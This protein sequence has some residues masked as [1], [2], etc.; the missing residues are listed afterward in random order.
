M[1]VGE[2]GCQTKFQQAWNLK[3][4]PAIVRVAEMEGCDIEMKEVEGLDEI[5]QGV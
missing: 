3:W 4:T 2:I 5:P 1:V